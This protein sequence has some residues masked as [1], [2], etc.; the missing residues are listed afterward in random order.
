MMRGGGLVCILTI[1]VR[2]QFVQFA[3]NS[4]LSRICIVGQWFSLD[5]HSTSSSEY[6][7]AF[8]VTYHI[9]NFGN[10]F[11]P[12]HSFTSLQ[13]AAH[14]HTRPV[15]HLPPHALLFAT[16]ASLARTYMRIFELARRRSWAPTNLPCMDSWRSFYLLPLW[17][18]AQLPLLAT[19]LQNITS[20]IPSPYTVKRQRTLLFAAACHCLCLYFPFGWRQVTTGGET[21]TETNA[22]LPC[23]PIPLCLSAVLPARP[24]RT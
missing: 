13:H 1:L 19:H 23:L 20:P 2:S 15:F 14:T 18:T 5:R 4:L 7:V 17:L 12:S 11:P 21:G 8:F 24:R 6:P 16:A 22:Y 9:S 3:M 10:I